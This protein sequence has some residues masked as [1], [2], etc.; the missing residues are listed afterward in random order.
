VAQS[1]LQLAQILDKTAKQQP[2]QLRQA[3]AQYKA[4]MALAPA[5]DPSK[6]QN[7]IAKLE[8]KAL[9]YELSNPLS[10]QVSSK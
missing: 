10:P 6:L 9:K 8:G 2:L 5:G 3:I 7:R 1:H 4:Y